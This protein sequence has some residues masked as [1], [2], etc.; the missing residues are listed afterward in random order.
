[1][2]TLYFKNDKASFKER[3]FSLQ[4][5][6]TKHCSK[7]K[8]V[9]AQPRG[10][11]LRCFFKVPNKNWQNWYWELSLKTSAPKQ[12]SKPFAISNF[13]FFRTKNI[14]ILWPAS[15]ANHL[16]GLPIDKETIL[17]K[18]LNLRWY[19]IVAEKTKS[20]RMK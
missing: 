19:Q 15:K 10:Q 2:L 14:Q 11:R 5:I 3:R 9:N 1:M 4:V 16:I 17:L 7:A 20:Q 18:L 6:P 12:V 13:Q 8:I